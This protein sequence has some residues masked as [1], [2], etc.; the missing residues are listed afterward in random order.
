MK[1]FL[2]GAI[3]CL[4]LSA[5]AQII[6][7]SVGAQVRVPVVGLTATYSLDND[8]AEATLEGETIV[9]KGQSPCI[10][11]IVVVAGESITEVPVMV[12]RQDR[13]SDILRN[14]SLQQQNIQE[15]GSIS[16]SYS[17][18]P[19]E[20][21]TAV[22]LSRNQGDINTS[23]AFSLANGYV[24][25]PDARRTA[26]PYASLRFAGPSKSVT[27]FDSLVDLSPLTI[28]NTDLRGLHIETRTWFL[29]AGIASLT[30][31][32]QG[33]T[34]KDPDRTVDLGYRMALGNHGTLT[35]SLQW[36]GASH[37]YVSGRSGFIGSLLY[38]Y[39]L[40]QHFHLQLET[41]AAQGIAGAGNLEYTGDTS[42]LQ[43]H[44]RSTPL[45]FAG[46][47]MARPRGFQGSGTFTHSFTSKL[48][49]DMA[50][51]R[52][53]YALLDG[54]LQSNLTASVRL[55]YRI[56]HFSLMGGVGGANLSRRA[57][58]ALASIS[59]PVG[60]NFDSH[61][62][63]N[64][65]QYQFSH[66]RGR[67]LGSHSVRDSARFTLGKTVF[68]GYVGRQTQTPTVNY[69]LGNVPWL[70][71]ALLTAGVNATTPE[72]IQ[73]FIQS[74]TDLIAG[75]YVRDLNIGLASVRRQVGAAIHWTAPRNVVSAKVEWRWDN[76]QQL[77]GDV[78]STTVG[79]NL[80]F[81]LNRQTDLTVGASM[82][83]TRSPQGVLR[84]P[85]VTVGIR[86]QLGNV[87]D[88]MTRLQQRAWVRG[89]VFADPG[90]IGSYDGR[91]TGL[92]KITVILDG[93][94]RTV[95]DSS[96][97]YAFHSLS[98]GKHTVEVQYESSIPFQF[99]TPPQV[100]TTADSL[101]NFGVAVRK[102]MLM[103]MV[104]NDAQRPLSNVLLKITGPVES[105]VRTS[106]SGT[107]TVGK[108]DPGTYKVTLESS[109]L[110]PSHLMEN[111]DTQTVSV[112]VDQPGRVTF[113]ARALRSVSGTIA[114]N[115]GRIEAQRAS[116]HFD[117]QATAIPVDENG[118]FSIR[119]LSS[120]RHELA[121]DYSGRQHRTAV[122]APDDAASLHV[123]LEACGT[124]DSPPSL[125]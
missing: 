53:T 80:A 114:C 8:C 111:P 108:L 110:P 86:R 29:Q 49:I 34:E 25:S 42:R 31:F 59:V 97:H 118:R 112:D 85:L 99:T 44:V 36:I 38:D 68:T 95:T 56:R 101:I 28:E 70:R 17:S 23:V 55:L 93:N 115:G 65:F 117:S 14:A 12:S 39:Q 91:Q 90:E 125:H 107:F 63:G 109:S 66:N 87:P 54:G 22:N 123:N 79:G 58:P 15:A 102:G 73:Q 32:R 116:L 27:L 60:V 43:L 48:G 2:A 40:P 5:N 10:T 26:I 13:N 50:T 84:A 78:T 96:G 71:Q 46:L 120:G 98:E 100:D 94:H 62:F 19:G 106:D 122:E 30:N 88:L 74:N 18:N 103:G 121:L 92:P 33:I 52:D 4:T 119:D 3:V 41:A 1:R 76:Y 21:E 37:Q 6:R 89:T 82:F 113:V 51:T 16:T 11:H 77:S 81:R 47:S 64:S 61:R 20:V 57:E 105:Q 45:R 83:N 7:T 35:P 72:E 9:V 124:Q 104:R 75:G 24:L 67:D 69:L